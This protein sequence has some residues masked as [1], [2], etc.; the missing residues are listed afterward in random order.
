MDT[1]F[2]ESRTDAQRAEDIQRAQLTAERIN[3]L[4]F[5]VQHNEKAR[6]NY[7]SR[8]QNLASQ[9][10]VN[11]R[12]AR[13]QGFDPNSPEFR[14]ECFRLG[15][16]V[17][18]GLLSLP[19]LAAVDNEI[20]RVTGSA[21]R[22]N[23]IRQK[24]EVVH[25]PAIENNLWPQIRTEAEIE[26]AR[27]ARIQ[28]HQRIDTLTH[29]V[30][31]NERSRVKY[32]AARASQTKR[33]EGLDTIARNVG[34]NP[35]SQRFL[36]ARATLVGHTEGPTAQPL[37]TNATMRRNN[38][39]L[40]STRPSGSTPMSSHNALTTFLQLHPTLDSIYEEC[41]GSNSRIGPLYPKQYDY[42]DLLE[43]A[44]KAGHLRQKITDILDRWCPNETR[45]LHLFS[46]QRV[47]DEIAR[48]DGIHAQR[49]M[50][51]ITRQAKV[52]N[53]GVVEEDVH[54][55]GEVDK[56]ENEKPNAKVGPR[57]GNTDRDASTS[58]KD[59]TTSLTKR[60]DKL[61]DDTR[62]FKRPKLC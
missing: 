51:K 15:M 45:C 30:E 21:R 19:A 54:N 6:R 8:K 41:G 10:L 26:G 55:E 59:E 57:S 46:E 11:D 27:L 13:R 38:A 1:L 39:T 25:E 36:R 12:F 62:P 3:A 31:L 52:G 49:T 23:R 53:R 61:V 40:L 32:H 34:V 43:V 4:Q 14:S 16:L 20:Q 2:P 42:H 60:K 33:E 48:Q 29:C 17:A 47:A 44:R 22:S 24:N 7:V 37:S 56:N 35:R 9:R 5:V 50:L 28:L 58:R 18:V